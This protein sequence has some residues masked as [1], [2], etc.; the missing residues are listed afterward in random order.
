MQE[1]NCLMRDD[2]DKFQLFYCPRE[3]KQFWTYT[4]VVYPIY[5]MLV[6]FYNAII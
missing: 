3:Q 4:K 2:R 5:S 1:D 6:S